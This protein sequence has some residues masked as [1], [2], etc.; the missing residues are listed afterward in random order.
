M[1]DMEWTIP[2]IK[3]EDQYKAS[4]NIF[5]G[6]LIERDCYRSQD[7][8]TE[9]EGIEKNHSKTQEKEKVDEVP[10]YPGYFSYYKIQ[11]KACS[12][13]WNSWFV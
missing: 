12:R 1:M 3:D 2:E 7:E 5:D 9:L 13:E 8:S 10:P 4:D 11:T 6:G